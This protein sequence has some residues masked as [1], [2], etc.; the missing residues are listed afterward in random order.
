MGE[1][2]NEYFAAVFTVEKNMEFRELEE[3]NSDI[4]KNV[5]ITEEVVLDILQ[6]IK[7]D[8]FPGPDQV[9]PRTLWEVREV[10]AGPLTEIFVPLMPTD[11]VPEDWRLA[12][13]VPL[14]KKDSKEKPRNYRQ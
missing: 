5:H 10:I 2:L 4:L 13:I 6:H 1:I 9:Y 11:E 12:N 8:K 7:V 14:F 3:I